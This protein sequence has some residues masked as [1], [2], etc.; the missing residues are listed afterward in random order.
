MSAEDPAVWE[1]ELRTTGALVRRARRGRMTLLL[2]GTV[3]FTVLSVL[4]LLGGG[5]VIGVVGI[6]F[7][8]VLGIPAIG[9]RLVTGRP[10]LRVTTSSVAVDR[11]EVPWSEVVGVGTWQVR[12]TRLVVVG[13]TLEGAARRRAAT[14]AAGR[15]VAP[16]SDRL[17]GGP[18]LT[19]PN[20]LGL[21]AEELAAWLAGVHAR[22]TGG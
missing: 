16:A 13:L 19:L 11:V 22:A 17:T 2:L 9:Y 3:V 20:G 8:G 15:L 18:A 10:V 12:R 6:A 5:A 21:P 1:G 7:F 14:N 4:A